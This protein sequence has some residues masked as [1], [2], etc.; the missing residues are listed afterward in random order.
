MV[1][2]SLHGGPSEVPPPSLSWAVYPVDDGRK[3]AVCLP[4]L[5]YKSHCGFCMGLRIACSGEKDATSVR[6]LEYSRGEATG[7]KDKLAWCEGATL[8]TDP[9]GPA[10]LQGQPIPCATS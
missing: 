10:G 1:A 9:P 4:R 6:T 7:E 8:D 5:G 3:D 2:A